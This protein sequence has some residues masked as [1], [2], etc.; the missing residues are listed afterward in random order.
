MGNTQVKGFAFGSV[1]VSRRS[2]VAGAL[3][4]V[5][6][7]PVALAALP[8]RAVAAQA[9]S[10][11]AVSSSDGLA[12]SSGASSRADRGASSSASSK[13]NVSIVRGEKTGETAESNRRYRYEDIPQ[14]AFLSAQELYDLVQSGAVERRE[15]IILDIRSHRDFQGQMIA[16]SRNIPAGRQIDIRMDEIPRDKQIVLV[17]LKKSNRLAETWY[18]LAGNGYDQSLLKVLSGGLSEWIDAGYPTLE[19]QF[20]GC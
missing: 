3:A 16:D 10:S 5:G 13:A 6:V 4:C 11:R 20:L 19:D 9:V 8:G 14:E 12:A 17:A 2:F 15:V 7:L 1:P 18:T